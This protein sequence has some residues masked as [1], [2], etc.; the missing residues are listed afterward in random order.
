MG[1]T[2]NSFDDLSKAQGFTKSSS[3]RPMKVLLLYPEFPDTFW[4]FKHAL[5]FIHKKA[6]LPPLGLLTVAAMLPEHWAKHLVD[7]NV[8]KLREKDL[9]W[10]CCVYQRDDCPTGL[11]A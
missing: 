4:S 1:S 2:N 7:V 11:G 5:K 10:E 6:A 3:I 9:A 8:R